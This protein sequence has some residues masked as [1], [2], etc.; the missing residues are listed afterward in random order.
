MLE[1]FTLVFDDSASAAG[2]LPPA[3]KKLLAEGSGDI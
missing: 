2:K 3:V 1:A